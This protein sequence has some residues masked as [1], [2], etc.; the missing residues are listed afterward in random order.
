MRGFDLGLRQFVDAFF[1]NV[2][3]V[4][5]RRGG[6][7]GSGLAGLQLAPQGLYFVEQLVIFLLQQVEPIQDFPHVRRGLSRDHAGEH[8]ENNSA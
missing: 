7:R 5:H 6:G 1:G 4:V 3:A 8:A 2:E